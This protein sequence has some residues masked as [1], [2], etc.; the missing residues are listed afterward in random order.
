VKKKG[1]TLTEM[2]AAIVILALIIALA[3]TAYRGIKVGLL[4]KDYENLVSYLETKAANYS[5][6]TGELNVTVERLIE[7]GYVE[8]DEANKLLSPV[9]KSSMNCYMFDS[10]Y[11]NGNYQ[12]KMA[13]NIGENTKGKS[14]TYHVN[15]EIQICVQI[16]SN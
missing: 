1:F 16:N 15:K 13:D 11:T 5:E 4:R 12:A 2:V 3:V 8:P 7:T 10:V 14:N 9:D 6:D